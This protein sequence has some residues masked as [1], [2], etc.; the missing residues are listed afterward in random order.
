MASEL[1]HLLLFPFFQVVAI[2]GY[3]SSGWH[4][5]LKSASDN[6]ESRGVKQQWSI[7]AINYSDSRHVSEILEQTRGVTLNHEMNVFSLSVTKY[8]KNNTG[9]VWA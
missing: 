2:N 4:G 1:K 8:R 7:S 9:D 6:E 5:H 3:S